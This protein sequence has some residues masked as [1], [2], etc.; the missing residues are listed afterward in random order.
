MFIGHIKCFGQKLAGIFQFCL[1]NWKLCCECGSG[2]FC[3]EKFKYNSN[4]SRNWWWY[5]CMCL[6][7][8]W[9][10]VNHFIKGNSKC[11]ALKYRKEVIKKYS[12]CIHCQNMISTPIKIPIK[13]TIKTTI[14][15]PTKAPIKTP[16][17]MNVE[18]LTNSS[19][20]MRWTAPSQV[21]Q[22][23]CSW[24]HRWYH[25]YEGKGFTRWWVG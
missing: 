1:L 22:P 5:P 13:T 16:I 7:S 23:T 3:I 11:T 12:S 20:H 6:S 18:N 24:M 2:S 19:G 17:K 8:V 25:P 10:V 14:K 4:A 21:P 9:S 15:M